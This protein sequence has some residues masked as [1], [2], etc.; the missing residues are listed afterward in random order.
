MFLFRVIFISTILSRIHSIKL[1]TLLEDAENQLKPDLLIIMN[2]HQDSNDDFIR[3]LSTPK[4]ILNKCPSET[5][6]FK[7]SSKV[8]T[9]AFMR[10]HLDTFAL[11]NLLEFNNL[12]KILVILASNSSVDILDV[13][14]YAALYKLPNLLV[15]KEN[16][17]HISS[18]ELGR[19]EIGEDPKVIVN[20]QN[21]VDLF[22]KKQLNVQ[23]KR[24][25]LLF[26]NEIPSGMGILYSQNEVLFEGYVLRIFEAFVEKINGSFLPIPAYG[27]GPKMDLDVFFD[28][29]SWDFMTIFDT[30]PSHAQQ[31]SVMRT[32]QWKSDVLEMLSWEIIVPRPKQVDVSFYFLQ[33]FSQGVLLLFGVL[34]IYATFLLFLTSKRNL[35]KDFFDILRASLALPFNLNRRFVFVQVRIVFL[36]ASLFGFI[37]VTL[38]SA[39]LGSFTTTPSFQKPLETV[40]DILESGLKIAI[41]ADDLNSLNPDISREIFILNMT[42]SQFIQHGDDFRTDYGYAQYGDRWKYYF[43]PRMRFCNEQTFVKTG[44]NL[45]KYFFQFVVRNDSLY[46]DEFNAFIHRIR[47]SGLYLYWTENSFLNFLGAK[48]VILSKRSGAGRPKCAGLKYFHLIFRLSSVG[49]VLSFFVFVCEVGSCSKWLR[50]FLIKIFPV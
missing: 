25:L 37:T 36:L 16:E 43:V 15:F 32:L 13:F 3:E 27:Q 31:E 7:L 35:C 41:S 46:K 18:Y 24:I 34:W 42:R 38:Y 9:V 22:P 23:E 14:L 28:Q 10:S 8:L 39:L 2:F 40:N 11:K 5:F 4:V 6:K 47:D 33:P 29:P 1:K 45:E 30:F 21:L 49:L 17:N 20:E 44:I 48:L 12:S 26:Q 19:Y 50:R